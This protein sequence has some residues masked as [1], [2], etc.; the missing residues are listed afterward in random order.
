MMTFTLFKTNTNSLTTYVV[1]LFVHIEVELTLFQTNTNSFTTYTAKLFVHIEVELTV[2][3]TN[4]NS[5]TMYTVKLFV[6]I[7]VALT[8]FQTNTNSLILYAVKLFAHIEAELRWYWQINCWLT[9]SNRKQQWNFILRVHKSL[10]ALFSPGTSCS[11]SPQYHALHP[12][13][14]QSFPSEIGLLNAVQHLCS[15]TMQ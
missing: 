14:S 8:L 4:T 3:Q 2:S 10:V 5:F 15:C 6:H 1:K 12:L 13:Y 7:E 11:T 9:V